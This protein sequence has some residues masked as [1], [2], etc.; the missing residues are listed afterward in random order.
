MRYFDLIITLHAQDQIKARGL[1]M[2]NVYETFKH[3]TKYGKGKYRA[4]SE[5]E[6]EFSDFKVTVVATQNNKN[7]WIVKSAWRSPPLPGT[8]DARQKK[9]WQKYNKAGFLGQLWL[10]I[11]Q[12]LGF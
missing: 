2:E 7:E 4:T 9:A 5:F 10:Q 3:P 11:K 6:K 12:Q 8:A 1:K